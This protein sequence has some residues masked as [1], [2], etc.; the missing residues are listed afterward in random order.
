MFFR[1]RFLNL[2]LVS[3]IFCIFPF[4]YEF[5]TSISD[6][7]AADAGGFATVSWVPHGDSFSNVFKSILNANVAFAAFRAMS[8]KL[9]AGLDRRCVPVK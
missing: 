3:I 5:C 7:H 1:N 6:V 4:W 9:K 2:V 8:Y